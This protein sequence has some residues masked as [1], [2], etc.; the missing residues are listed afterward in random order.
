MS[1]PDDKVLE[2]VR[3]YCAA[4]DRDGWRRAESGA[5]RWLDGLVVLCGE[6]MIGYFEVYYEPVVDEV[7]IHGMGRSRCTAIG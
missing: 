4:E 6:V 7:P 1:G 2:S 5:E 3:F